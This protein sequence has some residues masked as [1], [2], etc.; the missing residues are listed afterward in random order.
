MAFLRELELAIAGI[1]T[2]DAVEPRGRSFGGSCAAKLHVPSTR[3]LP[4][5]VE[6]CATRGPIL[7][8][9]VCVS[10]GLRSRSV[11]PQVDSESTSKV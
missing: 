9:Y 1:F 5:P 6:Y 2:R 7:C 11:A 3:E 4:A 8:V 10:R